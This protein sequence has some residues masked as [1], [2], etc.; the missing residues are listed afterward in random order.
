MKAELDKALVEKYPLIFADRYGDMQTTAMVWG[1]DCGDG[2]YN[3]LDCL[4]TAIQFQ[5]DQRNKEIDRITGCN[6]MI[7]EYAHG[8]HE[9][10][11]DYCKGHQ[12]QIQSHLKGGLK[13]VPAAIPQV[14][15]T[16][17]KEKFGTL[18]FYYRGGDE[19]IDTLVDFAGLMSGSICDV[20]GSPGKIRE[21][22]WITTR[23]DIHAD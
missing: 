23:C 7:A 8:N 14:V 1:F 19:H 10:L 18:R 5:I 6:N 17:V 9:P 16:Q 20:C 11:F 12:G 4:C 13:T 2:W 22:G 3:L 15:A 21:G